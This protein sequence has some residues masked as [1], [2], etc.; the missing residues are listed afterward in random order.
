M[1]RLGADASI[2]VENWVYR[3]LSHFMRGGIPG[4]FLSE[5]NASPGCKKPLTKHPRS[6]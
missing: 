4:F 6:R 2:R 1:S 5:Y 3:H